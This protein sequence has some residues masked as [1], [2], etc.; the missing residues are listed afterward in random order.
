MVLAGFLGAVLSELLPADQL[1]GLMTARGYFATISAVIVVALVGTFLPLPMAMDVILA[2]SLYAMGVPAIYVMPILF[3]TGIYSILSFLVIYRQ[4]SRSLAIAIF[5][6]VALLGI[7]AGFCAHHLEK[8]NNALL[9]NYFLKTLA[10]AS[11]VSPLT[12]PPGP[13]T[14]PFAKLQPELEAQHRVFTPAPELSTDSVFVEQAPLQVQSSPRPDERIFENHPGREL[15]VEIPFAVS[16]ENRVSIWQMGT[17]SIGAGDIHGDGWPDL[18][19]ANDSYSGGATLFANLGGQRFAA[20]DLDLGLLTHEPIGLT[21]FV[22]LDNDGWLDLFLASFRQGSFWI[23]NHK[24]DFTREKPQILTRHQYSCVAAAGFADLNQD[25]RLDPVMGNWTVG[26][27]N[28]ETREGAPL[29]S[30]NEILFST[31]EGGFKAHLLP[32]EPG[33]TL[34]ILLSDIN[35]DGWSD[36]LVGNDLDEP[37]FIYLGDEALSLTPVSKQ[38]NLLPFTPHF[39]MGYESADLDN[40]LR[41]ELLAVGIASGGLDRA[42]EVGLNRKEFAEKIEDPT[43]RSQHLQYDEQVQHYSTV[44]DSRSV[45]RWQALDDERLR[46]DILGNLAIRRLRFDP[47]LEGREKFLPK[48]RED[49]S[50]LAERIK[51]PLYQTSLEENWRELPQLQNRNVLLAPAL[52]GGDRFRDV[53]EQWDIAHTGWTWNAKFADLNLDGWQDIFLVNGWPLNTKHEPNMLLMNQEGRKFED[54][55]AQNGIGSYLET[56]AYTYVDLDLDG[57]QDVITVPLMGPIEWHENLSAHGGNALV[58]ELRDD[59]G[60]HF[61]IGAQIIIRY[62][63]GQQIREIKASGGY[64]SFDPLVAHF[65]LGEATSATKIEVHWPDR[66]VTHLPGPFAAGNCYRIHRKSSK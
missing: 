65:G 18:V 51:L 32:E 45:L 66:K 39:N 33:E 19:V 60:N 27:A 59:T 22:D 63:N 8:A 47:D 28:V 55:T 23:R 11:E 53:T 50:W 52:D 62:P 4:M 21:A 1:L 6:T 3:T 49:L 42:R 25:G 56:M 57:D 7:T 44:V 10:N 48:H 29:S 64:S 14:K 31:D 43:L 36:L 12:L 61:A 35:H 20:Q 2:A 34:S 5:A 15:G 38:E 41:F 13:E 26:G 54:V 16:T 17:R 30:Q 37:D 40:D 24:G 58:V 46:Q 9:E